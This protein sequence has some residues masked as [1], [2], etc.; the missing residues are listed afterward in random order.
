MFSPKTEKKNPNAPNAGV[1]GFGG[2]R[3]AGVCRLEGFWG[4]PTGETQN[5]KKLGFPPFKKQ[6]HR[7][8]GRAPR[9]AGPPS[10]KKGG[11]FICVGGG[12]WGGGGFA[13]DSWGEPVSLRNIG[14]LLT[15]GPQGYGVPGWP[16]TGPLRTNGPKF[17]AMGG[18][19][20]PCPLPKGFRGAFS[21]GG[22]AAWRKI[23]LFLAN[24][25]FGMVWGP[26][27]L[28]GPGLPGGN[29][30]GKPTI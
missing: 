6:K 10:T 1:A 3:G 30:R 12:A 20:V 26:P 17:F 11:D 25:N 4:R 5:F 21:K 14:E 2:P 24:K 19:K 15:K 8:G 23:G 28:A 9:A 29:P 22:R 13:F 16:L 7:P 27:P 18:A